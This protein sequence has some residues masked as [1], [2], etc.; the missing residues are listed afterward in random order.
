MPVGGQLN[1]DTN[2]AVVHF[3]PNISAAWDRP[4]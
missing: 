3:E 1:A 2:R 4:R